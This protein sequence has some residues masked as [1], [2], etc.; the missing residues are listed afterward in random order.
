MNAVPSACRVTHDLVQPL[1]DH[2]RCLSD[3][4]DPS[5]L[6]LA[7]SHSLHVECDTVLT[8][9]IFA[10]LPAMMTVQEVTRYSCVCVEQVGEG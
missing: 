10:H 6:S 4:C 2:S 3:G 5:S 8:M 7:R 1:K 9:I